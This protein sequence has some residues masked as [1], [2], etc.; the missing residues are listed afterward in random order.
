MDPAATPAILTRCRAPAEGRLARVTGARL[1][2]AG[3]GLP[4]LAIT[5]SRCNRCGACLRLGCPAISDLGG[6]ALVVDAGACNGCGACA[7]V[8]RARAIR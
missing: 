7:P 2:A 8:C 4:P 1:A 3:R 6:E 5:P